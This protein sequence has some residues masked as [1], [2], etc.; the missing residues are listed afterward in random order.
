MGIPDTFKKIPIGFGGA[1][2]SGEGGGYGFGHID[3]QDACS[4]LEYAFDRGVRIFDTAPVYG[5][6]LSEKRMGE[7]LAKVREDVYIISKSGICWDDNKRVKLDNSPTVAEKMLKDSLSRLKTDYIDLYMVHWPDPDVDIRKTL[8]VYLDALDKNLIRSIG[9][10]N[11][12]KKD[13]LK[14]REMAD[15]QVLQ[16]EYHLFCRNTLHKLK[17]CLKGR[18][19]MSWGTLDKGIITGR[20]DEKS[21]F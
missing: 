4:L 9:L 2:I 15:I 3:Q 14:A 18:D 5:F 13:F 6:G 20:V 17:D 21:L 8:E 10:C 1:S 7:A 16:S 19:F 12:N 11:T